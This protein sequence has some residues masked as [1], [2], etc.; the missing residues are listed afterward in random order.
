M[1]CVVGIFGYNLVPS[2]SLGFVASGFSHW[3]H[4]SKSSGSSLRI[5]NAGQE[6]RMGKNSAQG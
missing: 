5:Q 1:L 6:F 4:L 3:Q 2:E